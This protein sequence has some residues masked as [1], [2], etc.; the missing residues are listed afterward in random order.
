MGGKRACKRSR[1]PRLCCP[2]A[3]CILA[4]P[5]PLEEFL[6]PCWCAALIAFCLHRAV[7]STF[8]GIARVALA[9]DHGVPAGAA[10]G[11]RGARGEPG[12]LR[13][14]HPQQR[15]LRRPPPR[16]AGS[17]VQAE[18]REVSLICSISCCMF[19]AL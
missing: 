8:L 13:P 4:L 12:H 18:F 15:P 19:I 10:Q 2:A 7:L 3:T 14:P 5:L 17:P 1:F 11:A 9:G 16:I 6:S